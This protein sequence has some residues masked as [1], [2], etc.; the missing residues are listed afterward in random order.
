M[1]KQKLSIPLHTDTRRTG[2]PG[3]GR[4]ADTIPTLRSTIGRRLHHVQLPDREPDTGLPKPWNGTLLPAGVF[5]T[6]GNG[7]GS[8]LGDQGALALS[9]D[10]RWLLAVD[11]GSNQISVLKV[12]HQG[13]ELTDVV[14]S[15]GTVPISITIHGSLVYVLDNATSDNPGNIA[16]YYLGDPG[17]LWSIPGSIQPLS[18]NVTSSAQISFNPQGTVLVV[19]E[20]TTNIIDTYTLNHRGASRPGPSSRHPTASSHLD[21]PSITGDTHR[22]RGGLGFPLVIPGLPLR[23]PEHSEQLHRRRRGGT[24]LGCGHR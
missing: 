12:T 4:G 8:T 22:E 9:Q 18:G 16:G 19:T 6:G 24:L 1:K 15:N 2:V 20:K 3:S 14:G 11:A 21:S 7:T 13:L 17:Q 23:Q 5:S 10:G